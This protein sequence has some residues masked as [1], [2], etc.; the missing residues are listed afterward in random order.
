MTGIF[1]VLGGVGVMCSAGV[2]VTTALKWFHTFELDLSKK[3]KK[4]RASGEH[5]HRERMENLSKRV[6]PE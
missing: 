1:L 3:E 5:P 2:A 4:G 6:R